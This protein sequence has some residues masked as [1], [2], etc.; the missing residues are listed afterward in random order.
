M[1]LLSVF[2][3]GGAPVAGVWP[4]VDDLAEDAEIVTSLGSVAAV[5][6]GS[7]APQPRRP[8][9]FRLPW[10]DEGEACGDE[11]RAALGLRRTGPVEGVGVWSLCAVLR[12]PCDPGP[13]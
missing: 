9:W 4:P 1:V 7:T 6:D 2:S 3:S 8:D 10:Y 5:T 11:R 12:V 13:P